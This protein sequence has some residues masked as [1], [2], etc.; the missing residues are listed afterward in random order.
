[1]NTNK[2]KIERLNITGLWDIDPYYQIEEKINELI[3]SHNA[4]V[5]ET[6]TVKEEVPMGLFQWMAHW[7][8]YGYSEHKFC[9]E[10]FHTFGLFG[11]DAKCKCQCHRPKEEPT[12]PEK[13]CCEKCASRW[14][15]PEYCENIGDCPCHETKASE[16]VEVFVYPMDGSRP[17]HMMNFG[18]YN[19]VKLLKAL[20]DL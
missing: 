4:S 14:K 1:M 7:K 10:C 2:G 18:V 8:K 15:D 12:T 11:R 16:E 19:K 17:E 3:D 9:K 6:H 5:E 13:K 20:K